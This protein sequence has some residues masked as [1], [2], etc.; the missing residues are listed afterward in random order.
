MAEVA[1]AGADVALA[2]VD[3]LVEELGGAVRVVEVAT[4]D[5]DTT[6]EFISVVAPVVVPVVVVALVIAWVV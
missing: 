3:K 6:D 2:G 5:D 1:D 4:E